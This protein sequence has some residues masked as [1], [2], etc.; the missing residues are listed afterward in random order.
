MAG[1]PVLPAVP[2]CARSV[3]HLLPWAATF[4]EHFLA[5][6]CCS[7]GSYCSCCIDTELLEWKH[8][9]AAWFERGHSDMDMDGNTVTLPWWEQGDTDLPKGG[10]CRDLPALFGMGA[11][12]KREAQMLFW[13]LNNSSLL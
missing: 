6:A 5:R 11:V 8:R 12:G 13:I 3:L 9:C 2:S 7:P 4:W 10:N 1:D